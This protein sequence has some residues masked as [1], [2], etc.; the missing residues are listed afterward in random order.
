MKLL[1]YT[2][3]VDIHDPILGFFHRWI[4]EFSKN[5]DIVT[6]ICLE[7]GQ[8]NLPTNVSVVSLGKENGRSRLKY[9]FRFY[10]YCFSLRRDYDAVLVHMNQ[11]YIILGGIFW[12][13]M[14]KRI[15]FWRNHREGGWL[16]RIAVLFSNRVYCTS[17][18]AYVA[19]Y[20][21]TKL[22]PVG[23]DTDFFKPSTYIYKK[24]YSLLF[25]G[26]ISR[27]KNVNLFIEAV[28]ILREK[29]IDISVTIVGDAFPKDK[30]Y[31]NEIK[32]LISNY[33]LM[34][35]IDLKSAV[36]NMDTLRFYQSHTLYVNLTPK[37]SQDK[38]V[39]ESMACETLTLFASEPAQTVPTVCLI[40]KIEPKL[41]ADKILIL[42]NLSM[43]EKESL[44]TTLRDYTVQHHSLK[45]LATDICNE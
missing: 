10:Y 6:V 22:M 16:T 35:I 24:P 20:K 3:K 34:S 14:A 21:K 37:G 25:L 40:D 29:K 9:I 8:Y 2:Q 15:M 45:K 27:V 33:N 17:P 31:F 36:T 26:R 39:F 30:D 28:K 13:I 42:L 7:K 38:T 32:K 43:G 41:I 44:V 19:Y 5:Y 12:I 1:I 18:Y 4:E 11:E 23:I